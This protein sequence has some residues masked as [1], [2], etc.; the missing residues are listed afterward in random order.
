MISRLYGNGSINYDF[1]GAV[2]FVSL[3]ETGL[4]NGGFLAWGFLFFFKGGLFEL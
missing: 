4:I 3:R 1:D 2:S